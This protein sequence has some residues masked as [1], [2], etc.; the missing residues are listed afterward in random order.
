MKIAI[1]G[2]GT[3]GA[4]IINSF[5]NI[6]DVKI[7]MIIDRN[8]DAKG[9]LLAKKLGLRYSKSLESI[10]PKDTDIIIEATGKEAVANMIEEKFGNQC[11]IINSKA[12]LLIMT[13]VKKD[14]ETLQKMNNQIFLIKNTSSIIENQLRNI[15]RSIK[16]IDGVSSNL[17]E[18]TE[19]STGYIDDTDKIVKYVNDISKQTKILGIN[20]SIEAARAGEHGKGFSVV[21]KEVQKL[22]GS[23]NEFAKEIDVILEKL[24]FEIK[25]INDE[26]NK[27]DILSEN[28]VK[29]SENVNNAIQ[30]LIQE[31]TM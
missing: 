30:I 5:V 25:R 8:E 13:L 4:N 12:A 15:C 16:N 23:S 24:S 3:G 9:I 6:E 7:N 22:A 31:T 29:A 20:A 26:V 21:A 27:L 19:A 28:Q 10:N 11:T 14:I 1:V 17:L 2:A 18:A